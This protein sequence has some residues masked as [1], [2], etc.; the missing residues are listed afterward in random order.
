MRTPRRAAP[1]T[2]APRRTA[3]CVL[4]AAALLPAAVPAA[5][6]APP[7]PAPVDQAAIDPGKR[8]ELLGKGWQASGDRLWTTSGDSTGLHLLVAEARTGYAWRTAA[9]LNQPGVEADQWIGNVC[10]TG[11]GRRAVVVYAPRTYTNDEQLTSRGGFTAVV[12]LDGG[13]VTRLP[14][15]TSLAYFN[16]GCGAGETAALTQEGHEDLG[17]TGVLTVDAASG[18]LSPRTELDNQVTSATPLDGGFVVA[19]RVGLL[20]VGADG[21]K[22]RLVADSGGVPSHVAADAGGGVVFLD[23][24][25]GTARVRRVLPGSAPVTLATGQ[26]G[27]L[28]L[29]HSGGRAF[30]TGRPAT[31]AALPA[32][33]TRLDAPADA[34]VSTKGATAVTGVELVR[35]DRDPRGALP[36]RTGKALDFTVDPGATLTPRWDER[37]DDP[38]R[39]CS[40]PRNDVA[41][42]VYQ[43]KPKQVEWA[44]DQAVK[45]ALD[46]R[47]MDNWR[48]NGIN[49]YAVK[50][51]F[52]KPKLSTGGE[53]PAQI[54]LG[55]L[56][57]ESN[58][59]Q[60]SK[61][62]LPGEL[63]NP[64]IGNYYGA[65]VYNAD[66]G[67]DWT[68]RWDKADCGY[69]VSQMTDG[70]RL[71][72]KPKPDKP[73]D[74]PKSRPVQVA[75]AT[76]Y[77]A[78][79]AAGLELLGTKWNELQAQGMTLNNNDPARIEN[80]F[81]TVWAYNSGFHPRGEAGANGAWGLGWLNNPVN[82][83]YPAGRPNF[84]A[85]PKDYA[86]PQQWPYPE[87]VLGFAANPPAGFEA[88]GVEVPFFRAAWWN[89]A[90]GDENTPG[91]AKYNRRTAR[92]EAKWFCEMSEDCHLGQAWKPTAPE[93]A[94]EPAGPCA[95]VNA[96]GQYDLKCWVHHPVTWKA[97]CARDCGREFIRY[98][99]G[100]AE[101]EDGT[102]HAPRCD[103]AG[104]LR[105]AHVIDNRP[106]DEAP[107]RDRTCK[108]GIRRN[109]GT[110]NLTFGRNALGQESGKIDLHQLGSGFGG[111]HWMSHNRIP[112]ADERPGEVKGTWAFEPVI[113]GLARVLV[114]LPAHLD[115]GRTKV[116]F[117]YYTVETANGPVRVRLNLRGSGD[118]WVSLG[119]F[120]FFGKPKVHLTTMS[121]GAEYAGTEVAFDA[122]AVQPLIGETGSP[123]RAQIR[124]IANWCLVPERMDAT[125]HGLTEVRTCTPWM[126]NTWVFKQV[127]GGGPGALP[128]YQII[129]RGSGEC[130]EAQ[131][132]STAVGASARIWACG[133]G[134]NF[135]LWT[136]VTVGNGQPAQAIRNKETGMCL[137]TEPKG[138]TG[139][140]VVQK[141]CDGPEVGDSKLWVLDMR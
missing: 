31:V 129:D 43:P 125:V 133:P 25:N 5:Q 23:R 35:G 132:G 52:P 64:L 104:V 26:P 58:L 139:L 16:P 76:D 107:R 20:K 85:N 32:T 1:R 6:A 88:P 94:D 59:W 86:K 56:G 29:T 65:D 51:F 105:E 9:T 122:V 79:V 75:I 8:E 93:V 39:V 92:P 119:E 53:V 48:G 80:W 41:L 2:S 87:K 91:T 81:Y 45:G 78:N 141:P 98:D 66:P 103:M 113:D 116:G 37:T 130:L 40:V 74:K 83:R 60:A 18:K 110:F 82:P 77:A 137:H 127:E 46:V 90:E 19:D 55:V 28:G 27:E 101:P 72:G 38:D 109:A 22:K 108:D 140:W 106:D 3:L 7:R 24:D 67:D 42:Q 97:D 44:A 21:R 47:R 89:G 49:G 12:D 120:S 114:F 102:S 15:R 71:P 54:L 118:R 121:E 135:Q 11:S 124:H 50:D 115:S 99:P 13:A 131:N 117:G 96:A 112:N 95:H 138:E 68:I 4:A 14:V 10:L 128:V 111:H 126:A 36:V 34:L 136:G 57:Q 84:G 123:Y 17:R 100:F 61:Y 33:V 69:G 63:G 134:N 70:M 73:N 30:V 62:T